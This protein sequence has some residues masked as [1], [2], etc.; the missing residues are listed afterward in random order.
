M[1]AYLSGIA[2]GPKRGK[3]KTLNTRVFFRIIVLSIVELYMV[4][5]SN[6]TNK[7]VM[8]RYFLSLWDCNKLLKAEEVVAVEEAE[9]L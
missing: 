2:G 9:D 7:Y 3:K 8:S 1:R 5:Y 4:C 6:D